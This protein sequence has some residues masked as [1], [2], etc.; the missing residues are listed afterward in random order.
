MGF[1][2]R[3]VN[4]AFLQGNELCLGFGVSCE[5]ALCGYLGLKDCMARP[6]VLPY[7]TCSVGLFPKKQSGNRGWE[8]ATSP[9]IVCIT[10]THPK[11]SSERGDISLCAD[12]LLGKE[13]LRGGEGCVPLVTLRMKLP[14]LG[15]S[16]LPVL[17][18]KGKQSH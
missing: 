3:A 11:G 1:F 7:H 18:L 9:P 14:L 10:V 17:C 4:S 12:G 13:Q 6:L 5:N 8:K 15:C 2:I 16:G